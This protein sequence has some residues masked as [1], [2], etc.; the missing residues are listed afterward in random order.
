MEN[1][2]ICG[3]TKDEVEELAK[4]RS[5]MDGE[6]VEGENGIKRCD[7]C[8]NQN[9]VGSEMEM[10]QKESEDVLDQVFGKNQLGSAY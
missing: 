2:E 10:N 3:R 9:F 6:I 1:C 7:N 5:D 8:M 4:R